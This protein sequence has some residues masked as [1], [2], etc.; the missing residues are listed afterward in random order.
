MAV[1]RPLAGSPESDLSCE[2]PCAL[3][4]EPMAES[5][6]LVQLVRFSRERPHLPQVALGRH[7]DGRS[8][9]RTRRECD[10][11]RVR[12]L[13]EQVGSAPDQPA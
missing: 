6:Q 7:G 3:A 12:P 2:L 11:G 10:P 1:P 4:G 13:R 9:R 8:G 5:V